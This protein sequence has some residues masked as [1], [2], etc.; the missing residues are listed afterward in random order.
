MSD[1]YIDLLTTNSIQTSAN[2]RV[3]VSFFQNFTQPI[4]KDTTGYKF[5]I[6]RFVVNTENLPV[7]IPS[8]TNG[9]NDQTIYS[10]TME[11]NGI[12]SQTYMTW[13]PQNNNPIDSDEYYYCSSYQYLAYLVSLTMDQCLTQLN[14]LVN[15]IFLDPPTMTYD[16]TTQLF[17]INFNT[18]LNVNVYFN[19]AMQSLF[20]SFVYIVNNNNLNNGSDYQLNLSINSNGIMGQEISSIGIL[21]PISSIFFTSNLIPISK[22]I[23]PN[24][25]IY[26]DGVLVQNNSSYSFINQITDFIGNNL[27]FIPFVQYSPNIYRYINLIPGTSIQSIDLQVFYQNKNTGAIKP[28]YLAPG[29]SSSVKILITNSC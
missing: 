27:S 12:Y 5:S 2:N 3:Q 20:P 6:V 26:N 23:S 29:G 14:N 10:I 21:N 4:L 8:I 19:L 15:G 18:S 16:I 11:Y 7:F 13:I 28:L 24:I 17:S 22:T 9:T 25:Q 1:I